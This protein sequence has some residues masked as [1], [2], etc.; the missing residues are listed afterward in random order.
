MRQPLPVRE[1][2][3]GRKVT[4]GRVDLPVLELREAASALELE[5]ASRA[6]DLVEMARERLVGKRAEVFSAKLVQS[7]SKRTHVCDVNEHAFEAL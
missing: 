1:P 5:D 2:C 3:R 6:L 7:R 4:V